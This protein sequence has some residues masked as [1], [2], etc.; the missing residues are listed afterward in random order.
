MLKYYVTHEFFVGLSFFSNM[1][2][3]T[4]FIIHNL[5]CTYSILTIILRK[6]KIMFLRKTLFFTKTGQKDR[7]YDMILKINKWTLYSYN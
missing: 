4:I 5:L 2:I 1:D 3:V 7:K 6:M